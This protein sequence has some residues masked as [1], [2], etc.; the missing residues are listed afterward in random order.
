M[1]AICG[2]RLANYS[3]LTTKDTKDTEEI[4][5]TFAL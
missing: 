3:P 4:A 5:S 1:A 2:D